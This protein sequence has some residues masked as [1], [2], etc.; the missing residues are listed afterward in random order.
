MRGRIWRGLGEELL[1][2]PVFGPVIFNGGGV[3]S[4]GQVVRHIILDESPMDCVKPS[5]SK[6]FT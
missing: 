6:G 5:C 3:V 4:F 2:H 1:A